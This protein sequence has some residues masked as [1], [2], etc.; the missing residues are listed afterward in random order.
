MANPVVQVTELLSRWREGDRGA[1]E[2][3]LEAVYPALRA[4]AQKQL[5]SDAEHFTLRP[6]ELAHE[7]FL[8][9]SDQRVSWEN[10]DHF[11]AVAATLVRRVVVDYLRKRSSHKRGGATPFVALDELT[12]AEHPI[13]DDSVDWLLVDSALTELESSDAPLAQV[14]ELKFFSGLKTD[15]I[16]RVMGSSTATVGRQWR[17]AKAYLAKRLEA[18]AS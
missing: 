13:L 7:A 16:A 4:M 12:D 9:L 2:S 15:E 18:A 5:G 1:R 8:K 3:L 10:R 17:F 6:T 14:V 11:Y